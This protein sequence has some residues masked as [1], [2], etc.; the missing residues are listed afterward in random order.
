MTLLAAER[1]VTPDGVLTPGWVQVEG[2]RIATVG[3]GAPPRPPDRDL[4]PAWLLPGFIDLHVHG[5]G[6]RTFM[7]PDPAEAHAVAAFHARNGTTLLVASLVTGPLEQLQ[8][9]AGAIA[10]ATADG[11]APDAARILGSHLEGP[12]LSHARR[13][14]Q[15]P[16]HLLAPDPDAMARLL[17]AGHGTVRIVTVAPELPGALDLIGQ[18]TAGGA[19]AAVGHT[20]ATY[21]QAAA[22]LDA[23]ARLATHLFNG[24]APLHHRDPGPAGAALE[25]PGVVCELINDGEHLHPATVR[26]V[27]AAAG[28]DRVALVTDAM[29]AAGMPDGTYQLGE[30]EV[31]VRA[32]RAVLARGGALAGS[33]LTMG[34]AVRRAVLQVGLTVEQAVEAASATPARLLGLAGRAGAVAAG[35]DADLVVCDEQLQVTAVMR[36]GAWLAAAPAPEPAA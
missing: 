25:R 20:D 29:A 26:L 10:T 34:A 17:D 21:A 18:V 5:G 8:A 3:A 28:A 31:E 19:I 13:G 1:I 6:G 16:R 11:P 9:A 30:Q 15:D 32:G 7:N 33:T 27:L 14:A 36:G 2:A 12:F 24:M 23:G 35:H 4:G 22:G